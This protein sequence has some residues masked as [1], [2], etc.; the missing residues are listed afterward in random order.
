MSVT[1]TS[2]TA[3]V[4]NSGVLALAAGANTTVSAAT[5]T[6]TISAG[7]SGGSTVLPGYIWGF[8]LSNDATTPSTILDI[9]NGTATDST[10]TVTITGTAFTKTI[11][12]TWVSG[13][14]NAGM[15][16][17]LT[18]TAST[19]YHVFAGIASGSYDVF[20]DTSLTAAN[21]PSAFTSFRYIGSVYLDT[22]YHITSFTQAA[23]Y[24]D[25]VLAFTW[26][27]RTSSFGTN[28]VRG[29]TYG[30]GLYVAVGDA[31]TIETSPDGITWTA[32]TSSFG[33]TAVFGVTYGAGLY[34]AVGI[35]GTIE[36]S[37]YITRFGTRTTTYGYINPYLSP[38]AQ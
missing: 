19:W 37:T 2:G 38:V 1:T 24:I 35:T 13:T 3:T 12:G 16:T 10:G 30:A 15:G 25:T 28:I 31:G 32:R 9:A 29:V 6:V 7:G 20:F 18:A 26:T 36:T 14:G 4:A 22:N 8:T 11:S 27:A 5:G 23:Q 34:V 21:K 33:T 17:G